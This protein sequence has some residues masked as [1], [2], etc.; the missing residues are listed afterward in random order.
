MLFIYKKILCNLKCLVNT[1]QLM[2][3]ISRVKGQFSNLGDLSQILLHRHK[4]DYSKKV[5]FI[6][7]KSFL[8][9]NTD[10]NYLTNH[11]PCF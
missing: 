5:S 9:K 4:G 7:R 11:A 1:T 10:L 3:F 8:N 6:Q 2:R